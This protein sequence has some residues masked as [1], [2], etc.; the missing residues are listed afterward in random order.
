MDDKYLIIYHK[1][2]NDGLFSMAIIYNYLTEEKHINRNMISLF[3][4]DYNMMENIN[5]HTDIIDQYD[6]V[7]ITDISFD[8]A[9]T[10]R[11]LKK[12]YG[13]K[14]TWFDHHAPMINKSEELHF[15]DIPGTRTTKHSA[16]YNAFTYLYN[17]VGRIPD[18]FKVLSAWDSWSY[19]AENINFDFC[20]Y[21][22]IGV[23]NKYDLKLNSYFV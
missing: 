2:D 1:E 11:E 3:G 22:N 4:A 6:Y 19:E 10:M 20:R 15:D 5:I 17:F 14:L 9:E 13:N 8:T 16:L 7:Y 18:L 23:N 21:V 12:T